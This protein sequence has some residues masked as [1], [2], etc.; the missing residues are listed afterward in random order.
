MINKILCIDDEE[1]VLEFIRLCTKNSPYEFQYYTDHVEALK[2]LEKNKFSLVLSDVKMPG[3]SGIEF[4]KKVKAIC[5]DSILINMS[6]HADLDMVIDALSSNQI[7]DFI[8]KPLKKDKFLACIKKAVTRYNL[9]QER[10]ELSEKLKK[11]NV[12]LENWNQKLD[13]EVKNKTFELRL[14]DKLLQHLAGCAYLEDPFEPLIEFFDHFCP[15]QVVSLFIREGNELNHFK[16]CSSYEGELN[17]KWKLQN[18]FNS[19]HC[20]TNEALEKIKKDFNLPKNIK[21]CCFYALQRYEYQLGALIVASSEKENEVE[22]YL[23][24]LL[25]LISLLLHD[26]LANDNVDEITSKL[27][28]SDF[29]I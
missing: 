16:K 9:I 26:Q 21:S 25:P 27:S 11:Q 14:R 28:S 17:Q 10:N 4:L 23:E 5:S 6:S 7:Y 13:I 20:I 24:G 12:E 15:G 8:K 29:D 22:R 1:D 18:E 2:A 19:F 3:I